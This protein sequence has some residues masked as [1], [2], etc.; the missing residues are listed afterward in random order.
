MDFGHVTEPVVSGHTIGYGLIVLAVAGIALVLT[1][2]PKFMFRR[3]KAVDE[4]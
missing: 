1:S 3:G 2:L 4:R